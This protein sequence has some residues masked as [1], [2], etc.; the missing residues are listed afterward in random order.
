M[1]LSIVYT[2]EFPKS[3]FPPSI[4]FSYNIFLKKRAITNLKS[5]NLRLPYIGAEILSFTLSN[6]ALCQNH[7]IQHIYIAV[8]I[9]VISGAGFTVHHLLGQIHQ[10]KGIGFAIPVQV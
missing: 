5:Q 10:V 6:H 9:E 2:V 4:P 3:I 8:L 7:K 1:V